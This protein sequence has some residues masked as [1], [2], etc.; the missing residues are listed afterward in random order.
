MPIYVCRACGGE[1]RYW[2][3]GGICDHCGADKL[4]RLTPERVAAEL[5]ALAVLHGG[6]MPKDG[7]EFPEQ[8]DFFKRR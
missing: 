5:E 6:E 4:N 3:P 2:K 1:S 7:T 8:F